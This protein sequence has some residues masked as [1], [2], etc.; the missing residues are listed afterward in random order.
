MA[1]LGDYTY[2]LLQA[3]DV[4]S[5]ATATAPPVQ[6]PG[7]VAGAG[8]TYGN[9]DRSR[10]IDDLVV[11]FTD[12]ATAAQQAKER[13]QSF[14]KYVTAA[15]QPFEVGTNGLVAVGQS[16]DNSKSVTYVTFASGKVG[17][18]LEFD[19]APGDPA[20][21]DVVLDIARKQDSVIKA[22]LPG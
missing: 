11:V 20:P 8:V 9:T 3:S 16:P 15:P 21:Q 22:R 6:N 10:T 13:A 2:L 14:G 19:S 18:D 4:G 7:G 1:P 5:D 17:V 12:P